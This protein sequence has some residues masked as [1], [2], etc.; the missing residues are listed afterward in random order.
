MRIKSKWHDNQTK[1]IA[2]ISSALAF[3]TWRLIKNS[4][5]DLINEGFTIEK[6]QVFGVIAEY[7]CFIIQC[8][9]RLSFKQLSVSQRKQLIS[10]LIKQT[11]LY[12][13]ENKSERIGTGKHWQDFVKLYHNRV[14]DYSEFGFGS[15]PDYKFYRYFAHMILQ[16]T[17]AKD[18]KWIV[19]QMIEIQAP[20]AFKT[21]KK[22]LVNTLSAV[23]NISS[24]KMLKPPTPRQIRRKQRR[25][26]KRISQKIDINKGIDFS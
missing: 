12:Y 11:A 8:I 1:S 15:E 26:K 6:D 14:N 23:S 24:D 20:K 17:T 10:K 4:L 5:E 22:N 9:D 2:D 13:Q 18:E 16:L 21:V 7:A 25:K 19:Q 3:N